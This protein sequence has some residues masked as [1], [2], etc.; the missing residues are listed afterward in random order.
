MYP[1]LE[2]KQKSQK[3]QDKRLR[4]KVNCKQHTFEIT[5]LRLFENIINM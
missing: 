1:T 3:Q 4:G 2:Y 5:F